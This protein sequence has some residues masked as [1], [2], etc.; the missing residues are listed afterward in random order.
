MGKSRKIG[1]AQGRRT[2]D[3]LLQHETARASKRRAKLNASGRVSARRGPP[4]RAVAPAARTRAL[5][6]EVTQHVNR[7]LT[8]SLGNLVVSYSNSR[9]W[10]AS[11]IGGIVL[12]LMNTQDTRRRTGGAHI[13][14]TIAGD[15]QPG[16]S[17][18]DREVWVLKHI[19]HAGRTKH[20]PYQSWVL[21][22]KGDS[23]I[24]VDCDNKTKELPRDLPGRKT[25][26]RSRVYMLDGGCSFDVYDTDSQA[27]N[28][29]QGTH[30]RQMT[31]RVL[32]N[33]DSA[34]KAWHLEHLLKTYELSAGCVLDFP[35]RL[36]HRVRGNGAR[37]R[38]VSLMYRV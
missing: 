37:R 34:R 22:S 10:R 32:D 1:F 9:N 18:A 20:G 8:R 35:A 16:L 38:L 17:H 28:L 25:Q 21:E 5:L 12:P 14:K 15:I 13:Y 31:K 7:P 29:P 27:P 26:Y 30:Q 2:R 3:H 19:E 11:D 6:G 33:F 23:R 36:N 24:H 4:L